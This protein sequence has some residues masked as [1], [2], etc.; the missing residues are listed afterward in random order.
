MTLGVL[1][2]PT[3]EHT[4]LKLNHFADAPET[5]ESEGRNDGGEDIV[6]NQQRSNRTYQSGYKEGNPSFAAE[7]ILQFDCNRMTDAD[8]QK[9]RSANDHTGKIHV[10]WETSPGPSSRRGEEG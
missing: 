1:G 10:D 5:G 7:I 8:A 2:E 6:V 3:S 9:H 4:R